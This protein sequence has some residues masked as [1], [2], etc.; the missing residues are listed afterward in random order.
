VS[1][2]DEQFQGALCVLPRKVQVEEY[3]DQ[4]L[5]QLA[6]TSTVYELKA[7]EFCQLVSPLEVSLK[8]LYIKERQGLCWT[9]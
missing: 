6:T 4:C 3:N 2:S 1:L 8:T 9:S 5:Q 7:E